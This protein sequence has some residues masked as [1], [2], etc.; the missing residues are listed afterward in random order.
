[1]QA[2]GS[3]PHVFFLGNR[4]KVLQLTYIKHGGYQT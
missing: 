3:A 2:L 4:D 1:V